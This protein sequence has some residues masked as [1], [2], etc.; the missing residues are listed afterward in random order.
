MSLHAV[1]KVVSGWDIKMLTTL[2]LVNLLYAYTV[3]K[4]HP[5]DAIFLLPSSTI[6]LL[7]SSTIFQAFFL[8]CTLFIISSNFFSLF[9]LTSQLVTSRGIFFVVIFFSFFVF[10]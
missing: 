7:P 4:V 2:L 6:F 8:R 1:G 5:N 3:Q 10:C 9:N